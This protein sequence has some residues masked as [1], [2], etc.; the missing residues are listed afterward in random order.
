[1]HDHESC[2]THDSLFLAWK[3]W[4]AGETNVVSMITASNSKMLKQLKGGEKVSK[5]SLP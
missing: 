2:P 5:A 1:M 3:D 4:K